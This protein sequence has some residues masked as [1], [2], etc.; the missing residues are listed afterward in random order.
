MIINGPRIFMQFHIF[1]KQETKETKSTL[2][3]NLFRLL[4]IMMNTRL[5][6][7][8]ISAY[9]ILCILWIFNVYSWIFNI[10]FFFIK[11]TV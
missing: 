1:T 10:I 7:L 6:I 11:E 5:D 4:E 3:S 9:Y 2:H 8:H